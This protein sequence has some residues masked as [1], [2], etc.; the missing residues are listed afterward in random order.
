[1]G[2][3]LPGLSAHVQLVIQ[4][5]CVSDAVCFYMCVT[6]TFIHS[7]MSVSNAVCPFRCVCQ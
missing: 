2:A 1:M 7:V 5:V 6:F 3:A 4:C